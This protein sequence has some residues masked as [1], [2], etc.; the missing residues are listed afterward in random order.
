[1]IYLLE[2]IILTVAFVY[3]RVKV[4]FGIEHIYQSGFL[5]TEIGDIVMTLMISGDIHLNLCSGIMGIKFPIK[6]CSK[7]ES[8]LRWG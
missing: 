3:W 7:Y 2:M 5:V 6:T 8:F 4:D 1:M